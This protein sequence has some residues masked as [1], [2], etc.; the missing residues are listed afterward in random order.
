MDVEKTI[1]FLLDHAAEHDTRLSA[2]EKALLG[3][4]EHAGFMQSLIEEM[5]KS[6]VATQRTLEDSLRKT[7]QALHDLG[8]KTDERIGNL[9]RAIAVL[10]EQRPNA[11]N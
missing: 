6:L 1:Q 4:T 3:L 10:A 2:I 8:V 11:N 7:N 5:Q 9:V